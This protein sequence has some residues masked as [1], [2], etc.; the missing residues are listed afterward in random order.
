MSYSDKKIENFLKGSK[1]ADS[2]MKTDM[3]GSIT[4]YEQSNTSPT[5]YVAVLAEQLTELDSIL[6]NIMKPAEK[7]IVAEK[8]GG[9]GDNL[10]SLQRK[11]EVTDSK[12]LSIRDV[13]QQ[14]QYRPERDRKY[15]QSKPIVPAMSSS[16]VYEYQ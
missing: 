16:T 14:T 9:M 6:D 3:Y 7:H 10:K 8:L 13:V 1:L 4:K 2:L 15:S 11:L 5:G 12:R